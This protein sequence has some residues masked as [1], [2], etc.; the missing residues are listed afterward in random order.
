MPIEYHEIDATG[1]LK[2]LEAA[3]KAGVRKVIYAASSSA[4]GDQPELP[5]RENQLP[6]PI[7][8]YAAAKYVG[9]LYLTVYAQLHGMETL[10]LRYFNVFGPFQVPKSRERRRHPRHRLAR[11]QGHRPH[12][13]RRRPPDPRLLLHRQRRRTPISAPPKPPA[14]KARS[15][16]SPA[17]SASA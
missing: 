10:S 5:K 14:S 11:G 6:A 2:L 15:S 1:T 12:H 16:T 9:E 3:R 17:G 7:S 13:L 4:Y 8:P